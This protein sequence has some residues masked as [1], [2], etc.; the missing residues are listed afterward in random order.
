[1]LVCDAKIFDKPVDLS[2]AAAH[3]RLLSGQVHELVTAVCVMR[4]EAA[5]WR[6][7]ETVR[8]TMRPLSEAFISRYLKAEGSRILGCVGGYRLEGWGAQLF[9]RV[10]GDYFTVLG[11]PL[12]PLLGFLRE[13]GALA[14]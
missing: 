6:H 1:L 2:E 13:S 5:L 8:L 14:G 11:L 7:V 3:L 4:G 12:L 9:E 10:E